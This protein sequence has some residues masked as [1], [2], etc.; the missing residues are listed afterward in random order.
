MKKRAA[1]L[2]AGVA[3]LANT[4][5]AAAADVNVKYNGTPVEFSVAQP[6]IV[7]GRAMVPLRGL[8]DNMGFTIEWLAEEKTARLT[9][10]TMTLYAKDG[11]LYGNDAGGNDLKIDADVM[12]QL[13]NE[14]LYLPVRAIASCLDGV[15]VVWDDNTKTV[16]MYDNLGLLEDSDEG[17]MTMS[18]QTYIVNVLKDLLAIKNWAIDNK[19]ETLLRFF[20][21]R[22]ID[23][24]IITAKGSDYTF[25]RKYMQE[26]NEMYVPNT[27]KEFHKPVLEFTQILDSMLNEAE[28]NAN[29]T[30]S[31]ETLTLRTDEYRDA[32]EI[33]SQNLGMVWNNY[34][35]NHKVYYEGVFGEYT[36]D[37]LK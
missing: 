24:E 31:D 37:I 30:I 26:L 2:I 25:V 21:R 20:G 11:Y 29:G 18:E 32:K 17:T 12:P 1:L 15:D 9:S 3:V 16:N 35:V 36:L 22:V 6:Q 8:F 34:F 27:M 14:R 4:V 28:K 5:L 13:I 19:D 7:N 10:A 33:L 23:G